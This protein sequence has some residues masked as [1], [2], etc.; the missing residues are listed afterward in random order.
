MNFT[1]NNNNNIFN[2]SLNFFTAT[3]TN[4]FISILDDIKNIKFKNIFFKFLDL[5]SLYYL[6]SLNSFLYQKFRMKL[7]TYFFDKIIKEQDENLK[8]KIFSSVLKYSKLYYSIKNNN[9][10]ILYQNYIKIKTDYEELILKDLTRTFPNDES[11]KTGKKN[12]KKLKNLLT[13]YS[14]YNKEIGYAQGLNFIFGNAIFYFMKEEEVFVF[15][16]GLINKYGLNKY[17][18]ISYNNKLE[19]RL[20]NLGKFLERFLSDLLEFFNDNFLT[21]QFFTANW[22][23]TLLSTVLDRECCTVVWEFMI[24]FGW[25]F[26][27]FLIASILLFYKKEIMF[28][29]PR[30]LSIKMKNLFKKEDFQ[31]DFIVILRNCFVLMQKNII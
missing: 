13:A 31:K 8:N 7:F 16:D 5:K 17:F 20:E 28:E 3:S 11:F 2:N 9:L 21:H 1:I 23:I 4:K 22:V 14:N 12:Y 24:L 10:Y 18:C 27:Y 30:N 25:K 26:F 19:E 29:N 15:I 6:T